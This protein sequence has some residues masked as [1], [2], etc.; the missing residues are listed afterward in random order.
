MNKYKQLS[1][2]QRL[3][4]EVLL[5]MKAKKI[6]IAKQLGIN[7]TTLYREL[8][9]H[10]GKRGGYNALDAQSLSDLSKVRYRRP[11]KFTTQIQRIV[12]E[13]LSHKW[14][15]EQISYRLKKEGI[16][17]VSPE[18]IY[19]FIYQDK[20]DGGELYKHLRIASKSYRKRYG[21]YDR[22]GKI[23]GRV[24]IEQRPEEANNRERFGDWEADTIIGKNRTDAILTIVERQS[25]FTLMAKLDRKTA[26]NTRRKCINA[27]APYKQV[28]KSITS[29]NGSEFYE[30]KKIAEK[31]QA[32]FY[33]THPYSAWEK[34]QNENT[35]GLIRQYLPKKTDFRPVSFTEI[36]K[37]ENELNN[38]PRKKLNFET[39]LE[40]FMNKFV[41]ENVALV[42]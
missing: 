6:E 30:H 10:G 14:S 8:K 37:I 31:L 24:S 18:R 21:I 19:Q 36:N 2:E 4:L 29:D 41:N 35:N 9:R 38:R 3:Q 15:P 34:G 27:L 5:Q 1:K 23:P 39:P 32:D 20:Y 22:R 26:E 13:K 40:V 33:F 7:R 17:M 16:N 11:R 25:S 42:T 12:I 28:V